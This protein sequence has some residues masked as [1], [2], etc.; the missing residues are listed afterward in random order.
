M[1]QHLYEE[2]ASETSARIRQNEIR[3][4]DHAIALLRSA[5]KSGKGTRESVEALFFLNRLWTT[6]IEDLSEPGNAYPDEL[7]AN[8]ISIGIWV[9]RQ[10]EDLRQGRQDNF[11]SV[12]DINQMI[13]DGLGTRQ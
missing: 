12:L 10:A 7:K 8:L 4:F 6:I 13:R 11:Q 5:I 9:L 1:Y 2:I 3:A